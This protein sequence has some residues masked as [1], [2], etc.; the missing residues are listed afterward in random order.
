MAWMKEAV[1]LEWYRRRKRRRKLLALQCVGI[2]AAL[3]ATSRVRY[4]HNFGVKN[5]AMRIT[6]ATL[7]TNGYDCTA[8]FRLCREDIL[9]L[10]DNLLPNNVVSR[11]RSGH[12]T[13]SVEALCL[14]L[15]R[16]PFP[17]K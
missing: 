14:V 17:T 5:P 9:L 3:F 12:K 10:A 7:G 2:S 13:N 1:L 11:C 16:L 15:R 8:R 4:E 6:R